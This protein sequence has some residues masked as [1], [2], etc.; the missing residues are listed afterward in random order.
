MTNPYDP[1]DKLE[2]EAPPG[3]T[4]R[5]GSK[6]DPIAAALKSRPGQWAC[7]GRNMPTGIVTTIRKGGLI[8]FRPE[9]AFEAVVRNHTGRWSGDVYVRYV[10]DA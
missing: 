7:I 9:G 6:W 2:W 8:C 5:K 10:G 3:S 4:T 1:P